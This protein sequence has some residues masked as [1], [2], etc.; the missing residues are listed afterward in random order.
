MKQLPETGFIRIN[1]IIGDEKQGIPP[2]IPVKKTT[3]WNG[4]KSGRYPKPVKLGI[5]TTAWKVEDIH[6]LIKQIGGAA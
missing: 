3:W 6:A 1:Q 4:V 2:I 5:K